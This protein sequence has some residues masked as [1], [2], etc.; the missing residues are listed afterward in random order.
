MQPIDEEGI[1]LCGW[2]HQNIGTHTNGI[3]CDERVLG[4]SSFGADGIAS[5]CLDVDDEASSLA[6]SVVMVSLDVVVCYSA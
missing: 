5:G 4:C 2:G 1:L 6:G 3:S